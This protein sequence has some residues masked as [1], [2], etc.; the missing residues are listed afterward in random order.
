[1]VATNSGVVSGVTDS[2]AWA[3]IVR[4]ESDVEDNGLQW[5]PFS[6]QDDCIGGSRYISQSQDTV[7]LRL[8]TYLTLQCVGVRSSTNS[9]IFALTSLYR[10]PK[11]SATTH[12]FRDLND[13][14]TTLKKQFLQRKKW[15]EQCKHRVEQDDVPFCQIFNDVYRSASNAGQHLVFCHRLHHTKRRSARR[16]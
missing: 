5:S 13:L 2:I 15:F 14:M 9:K 7:K 1:M 11:V 12:F 3:D 16:A 8:P 6:I 10:S 4:N